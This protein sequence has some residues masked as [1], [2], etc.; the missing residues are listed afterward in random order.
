MGSIF[1]S[2]YT[3]QNHTYFTNTP[4]TPNRVSSAKQPSSVPA[5]TPTSTIKT[6]S[7]PSVARSTLHNKRGTLQ[8]TTT[9]T[10]RASMAQIR[11]TTATARASSNIRSSRTAIHHMPA[12]TGRASMPLAQ[13]TRL[14]NEEHWNGGV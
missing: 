11:I 9:T 6:R 4:N 14:A 12:L 13:S 10:T 3:Q 5:T 1:A 2:Y 8:T 7:A